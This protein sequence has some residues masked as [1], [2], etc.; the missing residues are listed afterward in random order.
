MDGMG[1]NININITH[2]VGVP[3]CFE[4]FIFY[5]VSVVYM[6]ECYGFQPVVHFSSIGRY[7][8]S[9]AKYADF[10]E[11]YIYLNKNYEKKYIF[12]NF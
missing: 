2:H 3:F 10:G 12:K 7:Y 5:L 1:D 4:L 11:M 6:H 9:S 8:S